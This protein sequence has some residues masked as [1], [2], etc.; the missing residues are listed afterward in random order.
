M[1]QRH[2]AA[3]S[4]LAEVPSHA[5]NASDHQELFGQR[6]G[7]VQVLSIRVRNSTPGPETVVCDGR[8]GQ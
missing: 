5:W 7:S 1:V 4:E 2:V 3:T 8:S 6:F